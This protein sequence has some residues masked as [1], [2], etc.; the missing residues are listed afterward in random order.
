MVIIDLNPISRNGEVYEW[1]VEI[2]IEAAAGSNRL[3]VVDEAEAL[4]VVECEMGRDTSDERGEN[5]GDFHLFVFD[6]RRKYAS[7]DKVTRWEIVYLIM[8]PI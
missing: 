8:Y 2:W 5:D 4:G 1:T 3:L 6:L 7:E